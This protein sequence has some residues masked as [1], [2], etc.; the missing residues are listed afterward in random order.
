MSV[1]KAIFHD[2][3]VKCLISKPPECKL[4]NITN[5]EVYSVDC[6]FQYSKRGGKRCDEFVFFGGLIMEGRCLKSSKG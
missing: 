2:K 1:I 3:H 4:E 6:L 5:P